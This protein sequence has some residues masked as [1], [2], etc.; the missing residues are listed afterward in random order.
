MNEVA[1]DV[2]G[3]RESGSSL[4]GRVADWFRRNSVAGGLSDRAG[5]SVTVTHRDQSSVTVSVSRNL[6][7]HADSN[8][9]VFAGDMISVRRADVIYVVGDVNRPS[10]LLMDGGH[11]SVLQA[12]ALAGGTSSTAKLSGARII[13]KG[14]SGITE[15]P[16]PLNKLLRAKAEDVSLQ[17]D[18]ILFV[19]A[20][21]RKKLEGR[22]AETALQ[23][24][25]AASL[26]AIRP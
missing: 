12:L 8:I 16:V 20:S 14:P 18:D 11:L 26:I 2:L 10:G 17:A 15:V 13:R 5:K 4:R 24:A 23:L 21:G 6:E 7:E 1:A 3:P 19:P 22:T 9:P 25:G